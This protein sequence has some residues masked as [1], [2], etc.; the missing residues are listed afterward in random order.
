M[1]KDNTSP[2]KWNVVRIIQVYLGK[3]GKTRVVTIYMANG[4]P[5][6]RLIIKLCRLPIEVEISVETQDFN[7]GRGE[8]IVVRSH[9]ENY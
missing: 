9:L 8:N 7:G 6:R 1:K 4:L 5:L 3:D 2:M